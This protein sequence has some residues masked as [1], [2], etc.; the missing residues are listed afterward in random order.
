MI[1]GKWD[2]ILINLQC[3]IGGHCRQT[4]AMGSILLFSVKL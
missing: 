1:V 4:F 3:R 2:L